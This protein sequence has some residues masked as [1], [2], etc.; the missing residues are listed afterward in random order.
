MP[1]W[2]A[3]YHAHGTGPNYGFKSFVTKVTQICYPST[4]TWARE[5]E[6]GFCVPGGRPPLLRS[7]HLSDPFSDFDRQIT[8]QSSVECNRKNLRI[9][10]SY[11][12]EKRSVE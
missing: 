2:F 11:E 3:A 1:S 5:V 10:L 6:L 9:Q 12:P 7:S 4:A 8:M